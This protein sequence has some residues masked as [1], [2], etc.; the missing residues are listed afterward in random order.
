M[1]IEQLARLRE[2]LAANRQPVDRAARYAHP[3]GWNDALDFVEKE[4][5]KVL[6]S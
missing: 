5:N 4:I 1:S 3:N 2:I 6:E